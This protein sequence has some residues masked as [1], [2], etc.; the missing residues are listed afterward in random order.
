MGTRRRKVG[1]RGRSLQKEE[2]HDH[3]E[4]ESPS[5]RFPP[6]GAP[7]GQSLCQRCVQ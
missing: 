4:Q 6:H 5:P 7:S 1:G 2:A 3:R